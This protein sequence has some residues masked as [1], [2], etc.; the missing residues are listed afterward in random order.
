MCDTPAI[1]LRDDRRIVHLTIDRPPLNILDI[2]TM[3]SLTENLVALA[4][5]RDVTALV[6]EARGKVFSAGV[7]IPEHRRETVNEM[8][9]VVSELFRT[10][11][12]LTMPTICVVHGDALGGG[13]ELAITCDVIIAAETAR[14]GLP[15]ITLG[16]FPPVAVACL[17][18]LIGQTHAADLILTGR[19]VSAS[20]GYSMG[21]VSRVT[22][23]T[24]LDRQAAECA[25]QFRGLSAFSL[26]QTKAAMRLMSTAAFEASLEKAIGIYRDHLLAGNDPHEGIEAFIEKRSPIW[27]DR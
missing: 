9:A 25:E 5:R 11:H 22:A 12:S 3:R 2:T 18:H 24:D 17:H 10:L 26:R 8:L 16:V 13:M 20:E 6:I 1:E 27:T 21:M 23:P 4:T 14:F 7:D 15:E 19:L